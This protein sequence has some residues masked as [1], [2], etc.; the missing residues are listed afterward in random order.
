MGAIWDV[1]LTRFRLRSSCF[2]RFQGSTAFPMPRWSRHFV[3]EFVNGDIRGSTGSVRW[4]GLSLSV[5]LG[6]R[7]SCAIPCLYFC[8][9]GPDGGLDSSLPRTKSFLCRA[10]GLLALQA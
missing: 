5:E 6:G 4:M 8:G 9:V 2:G 10:V 7:T 3:R 1:L